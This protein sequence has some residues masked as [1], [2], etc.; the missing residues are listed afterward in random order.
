M[1][2]ASSSSAHSIGTIKVDDR[3]YAVSVRIGYDGI[4]YVGRLV[5]TEVGK[6]D[7]SYQDHGAIPG[8]SLQDALL[9]A[10]GLSASDLEHRCHRARSERRRFG[11]LRSATD[12]MIDKIKYLNRVVVGLQRGSLDREAGNQEIDEIQRELLAIVGR[13]RRHAGVEDE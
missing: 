13:F 6:P 12:D 1:S 8:V 11:K 3:K 9:K 7:V 5:F 2:D 10:G 4:E